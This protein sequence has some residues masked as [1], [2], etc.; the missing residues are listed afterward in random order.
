MVNDS[1]VNNGKSPLAGTL[2]E[3]NKRGLKQ[4]SLKTTFKNRKRRSG[5][6]V[7]R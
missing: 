3:L 6:D 1:C 5:F 7:L 2:K 4:V